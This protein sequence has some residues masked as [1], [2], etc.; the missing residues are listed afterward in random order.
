MCRKPEE[1]G[2][3]RSASLVHVPS[4][5]IRNN[6]QLAGSEFSMRPRKHDLFDQKSREENRAGHRW[7]CSTASLGITRYTMSNG[8][9]PVSR[10]RVGVM[11]S[12][13]EK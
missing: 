1:P 8:E 12:R 9:K 3:D 7:K 6:A 10:E 5:L 4:S 13:E 11:D 2:S